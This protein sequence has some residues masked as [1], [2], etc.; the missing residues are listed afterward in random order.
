[1]LRPEVDHPSCQFFGKNDVIARLGWR[2]RSQ[3]LDRH[4]YVS[5]GRGADII[6]APSDV[7]AI[8]FLNNS[9]QKSQTQFA[10]AFRGAKD[11]Q[12]AVFQPVGVASFAMSAAWLGVLGSIPRDVPRLFVVAPPVLLA[13]T[14]LGLKL[15]GRLDE[16]E[17]CADPVVGVRRGAAHSLAQ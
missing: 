9:I 14:W 6:I 5:C 12:R 11:Q 3:G 2:P 1:M 8:G 10:A 17:A 7:P 16:A 15:Y 13:G 4:H